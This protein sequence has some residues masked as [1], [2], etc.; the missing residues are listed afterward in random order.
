MKSSNIN[1]TTKDIKE[2][3]KVFNFITKACMEISEVNSLD[4]LNK[5][6]HSRSEAQLSASHK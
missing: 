5:L 1:A 4:L 6:V 2:T 3:Y